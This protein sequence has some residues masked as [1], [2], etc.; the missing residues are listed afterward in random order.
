MQSTPRLVADLMTRGLVTVAPGDPVARARRLMRESG[1]AALPVVTPEGKP[2]G[3]IAAQ[4]LVTLFPEEARLPCRSV[5]TRVVVVV[6]PD[7]PL[8]EAAAIMAERRLHH[9]LVVE[10][11]RVVGVLAA[12]DFVRAYTQAPP[13][14]LS[15]GVLARR[16]V[17]QP[18]VGYRIGG[19]GGARRR[20]TSGLRFLDEAP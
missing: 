9:V 1:H 18:T 16:V 17:P 15:G 7:T 8:T 6:G 3:M 19:G 13:R 10:R 5:M 11:Q 2:A 14:R 20:S 12:S 4:R